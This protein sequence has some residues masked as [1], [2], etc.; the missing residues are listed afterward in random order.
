[1]QK[2]NPEEVSFREERAAAFV[3]FAFL[4]VAVIASYTY[5]RADIISRPP[6]TQISAKT[7]ERPM[8]GKPVPDFTLKDLNGA[9]VKLADYRGKVLFINI[10]ATWCAPCREE[11]PS[12]EKLYREMKGENFEMLAISIDE[13]GKE[14]VDPFVEEYGLTFPILMDP[15]SRVAKKFK[16][17]GVP[18]T[19]IV[20]K[21]GTIINHILGPRSW[22]NPKVTKALKIM[23]S[24][25]NVKDD[26]TPKV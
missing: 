23:A 16:T 2:R 26:T 17:T 5:L 10:W 3:P 22:D 21:N 14:V 12:M 13:K 15:T 6:L 4:C 9:T 11:M 7:A 1:M 20:D 18:E 25:E 19:F 24:S 8:Q